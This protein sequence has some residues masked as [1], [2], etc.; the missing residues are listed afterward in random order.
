MLYS[1]STTGHLEIVKWLQI[2][3]TESC[4]SLVTTSMVARNNHLEILQWLHC[5]DSIKWSTDVMDLAADK[6]HLEVIEGLRTNR[7]EG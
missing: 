7:K 6:G 4:F 5:Q 3:C 1:A 2:Y